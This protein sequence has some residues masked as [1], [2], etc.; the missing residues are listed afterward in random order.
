MAKYEIK[1]G[2]AIIPE[3][4]KKI[5]QGWH[6]DSPTLQ[7]RDTQTHCTDEGG[8]VEGT[9]GKYLFEETELFVQDA[10]Q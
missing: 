4:V 5:G 1:D 3:G 6:E 10:G 9:S 8:G 7:D 2:V